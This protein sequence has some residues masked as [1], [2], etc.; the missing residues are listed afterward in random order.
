IVQHLKKCEHFIGKTTPE[1][2]EE[3]LMTKKNNQPEAKE[4][5]EFLNPHLKLPDRRALSRKILE[6]AAAEEDNEM[7]DALR[8]MIITSGGRPYVWKVTDISLEKETHIK[9]MDKTN[10]MINELKSINTEVSAIVTD[11]ARPYAVSRRR[12][13][14]VYRN[15]VFL[16]CYVH[17]LNL[18]IGEIFKE[19]T[20]L[21][22]TMN[23]AIKLAAYFKNAK[24]KYFITKLWDQQKITY[25]KYYRIAVPEETHWNSYYSVILAINYEPPHAQSRRKTGDGSLH[26]DIFDIITL[27]SFWS[28]LMAWSGE[29][30]TCILHEFNDFSIGAYP[31][32]DNTYDHFGD[33]WKYWSYVKDSTT[34]LGLVACRL[35]GICIN[36]ATVE[37]LWSCMGFLQMKRRNRLALSKAL[38]M[39][40]LRAII[41]WEHSQRSNPDKLFSP[42]FSEDIDSQENIDYERHESSDKLKEPCK[43]RPDPEEFE[44]L[45]MNEDSD[46]ESLDSE[47]LK[48]SFGEFLDVWIEISA[49]E[50]EEVSDTDDTD[51]D[52]YRMPS[53]VDD[54]VHPAI[55]P[56]AK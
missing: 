8:V 26:R 7:Y 53:K 30:P 18:C 56:V 19:S 39:S 36:A 48:E 22:I 46:N 6:A 25:K 5:F 45:I 41:L 38:N 55:D 34:E 50:V 28:N 29:E 32:D 15:I 40:K 11:S 35:Y 52:D 37:C 21:K 51:E 23:Q 24:N 27:D 12:L 16:S 47:S 43:I 54:I 1:Q 42:N 2:R 49:R 14:L 10:A 44:N 33:I 13:R 31:F 4:L 3:I 20:D 17:Q 9:V